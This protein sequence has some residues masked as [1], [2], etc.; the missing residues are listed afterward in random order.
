MSFKSST[1]FPP[2]PNTAR[3][4]STK[5]SASKDKIIYTNGKTVIIR[6]L[7]NGAATVYT[8]H[9]QNTS[10]ARISPSGYY[11]AS[12]D[13]TGTV[14]VWDTVGADQVLK[15]EYRVLS[16]RINDLEWDGESKRI[17]AVGDG[18]DK[19]GHAF[20]MDTGSS[21]GEISGHSKAINA[22]AIRSQRPYRAA[23]AGDDAL[24]VFHQGPPYKFDKSIRTHTKFVQ[25]V[26]YAPSGDHFASVGSDAKVFVYDGKTG[27]TLGEMSNPH[28]GSVMACSWS[29]DSK[30]L[31]SASADCTVKLWDVE[32][33]KATTTWALGAGVNHQQLG[34]PT[35]VFQAPQKAITAATPAADSTF[36]VG[37]ADGRA[38]SYSASGESISLEANGH[39]NLVSGMVTSPVDG[40]IVS[41]GYDDRV[42]EIGNAPKAFSEAS[43]S[44][45]SQPRSVAVAGDSTIF[46]AEIGG[47][48]AVRS[49]QKV[50]SQTPKSTPSAVAAFKS[51]IAIGG[52]DGKVRLNEWDGKTLTETA[53]FEVNRAVISALAFSPDGKMLASGDSSGK[54]ILFDVLEKKMITSRW[55]FHSARVNSLS[56]SADSL[57]C[58]SGSLDTHVYIWSVAK[59]IKNIAIKNAGPGGIN[60]VFWIEGKGESGKSG[61]VASAGA[62]GCVHIWDVEFHT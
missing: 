22:V 2:N 30:S 25:D 32:T 38:F 28:T 50:F 42:R 45:A 49:N 18:R 41:I 26:R 54:I 53:V 51:T 27:D 60:T 9:I 24:I 31:V 34:V 29:P 44:T 43:F 17:I 61:Q 8:G 23:T 59:P 14:R 10:V 55:S 62:D 13:V 6:D 3:G 11:C 4:A 47:V 15:G 57:H 20:M 16:G 39:S 46:L 58:A 1:I 21:T 19:Y 37:T 33:C 5:L 56:W 7:N 52:E 48:E 36:I 12:A 40:T 35:R